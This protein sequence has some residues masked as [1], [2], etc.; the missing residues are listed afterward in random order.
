MAYMRAI[1]AFHHEPR[2]CELA[3][4]VRRIFVSKMKSFGNI[5]NREFG[6]PEQ[7]I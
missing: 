5:I 2:D 1:A 3:N 4:M 6:F 7:E